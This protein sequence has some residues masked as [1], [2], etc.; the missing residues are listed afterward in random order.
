MLFIAT[1]GISPMMPCCSA[2]RRIE[3]LRNTV[4]CVNEWCICPSAPIVYHSIVKSSTTK[5]E[6]IFCHF[7]CTLLIWQLFPL[8]CFSPRSFLFD[9]S[10]F[11]SIHRFPIQ[12]SET[13]RNFHYFFLKTLR[14]LSGKQS[15]FPVN[16][17][18][19]GG[20]HPGRVI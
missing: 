18:R 16:V 7:L 8:G 11:N 14:N 6:K 2:E 4:S 15:P 20:I 1:T 10:R 13:F 9:R 12:P 19:A 17:H 5:I 3:T